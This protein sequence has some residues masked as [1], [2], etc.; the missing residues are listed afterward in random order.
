[1]LSSLDSAPYFPMESNAG[2]SIRW[3]SCMDCMMISRLSLEGQRTIIPVCVMDVRG[4]LESCTLSETVSYDNRTQ[5]GM[6]EYVWADM[7]GLE[8]RNVHSGTLQ[9]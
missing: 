6:L 2:L 5:N 1:M 3:P 8:N 9:I 7:E 4:R